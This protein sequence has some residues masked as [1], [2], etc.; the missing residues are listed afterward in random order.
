MPI[1][2][3]PGVFFKEEKRNSCARFP[4]DL[5]LVDEARADMMTYGDV[6]C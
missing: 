6:S 1:S 2:K 3:F 5:T 4:A